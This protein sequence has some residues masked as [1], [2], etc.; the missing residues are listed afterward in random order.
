[1]R[2]GFSQCEGGRGYLLRVVENR[3]LRKT[4]GSKRDE[5]TGKWRRLHNEELIALYSSPNNFG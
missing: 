2:L 3:V 4:F 1:M 5:L